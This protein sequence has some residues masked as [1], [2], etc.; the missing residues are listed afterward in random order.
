M[1]LAAA[2]AR[3][4]GRLCRLAAEISETMEISHRATQA[5]ITGA[6]GI[7]IVIAT[8]FALD[9]VYNRYERRLARRDPMA[10]ARH[11]T[12]FT[13]IRRVIV[14]LVAAI[15]DLHDMDIAASDNAPGL[16]LAMR[17]ITRV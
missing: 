6:I 5:I 13:F 2:G 14:A 9:F 12:M 17:S 10:V 3:L 16:R 11:R 4:S 1:P 15:A 7:V 8:R